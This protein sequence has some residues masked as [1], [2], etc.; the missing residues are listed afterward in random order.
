VTLTAPKRT[1]HGVLFTRATITYS[2]HGRTKRFVAYP[3]T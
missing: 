3:A 1:A 2:L